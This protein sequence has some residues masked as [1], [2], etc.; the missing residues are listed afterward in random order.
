MFGRKARKKQ[1][2]NWNAFREF[3]GAANVPRS[4]C[5]GGVRKSSHVISCVQVG[6]FC[7][8]GSGRGSLFLRANFSMWLLATSGLL[9]CGGHFSFKFVRGVC[10]N[11]HNSDFPSSLCCCAESL[12]AAHFLC[13]RPSNLSHFRRS[14]RCRRTHL[15][16]GYL[17]ADVTIV[18]TR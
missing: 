7:P 9:C 16:S 10:N 8:Q 17:V 12:R 2:R 1:S 15:P 4:S 11:Y 3:D 6:G 5:F 14:K 13:G 18:T